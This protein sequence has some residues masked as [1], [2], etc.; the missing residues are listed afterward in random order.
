MQDGES[1]WRMI[2]K[3]FPNLKTIIFILN[4]VKQA[5]L[6]QLVRLEVPES[7]YPGPTLRNALL[8]LMEDVLDGFMNRT[9]EGI[10]RDSDG[11]WLEMGL[12][13]MVFKEDKQK[14][15]H[16]GGRSIPDSNSWV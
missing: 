3:S 10:E 7:H 1:F 11:Y 13:C 8:E 5:N 9:S 2:E 15:S 12:D 16:F 6:H 4:K 14:H